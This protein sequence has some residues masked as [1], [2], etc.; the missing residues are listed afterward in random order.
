M[1]QKNIVKHRKDYQPSPYLINTVNLRFELEKDAA[2]V[3]AQLDMA[4]AEGAEP[5][6]L[7]LN[8]E[9]LELISV[10]IDGKSL[11][12]DEYSVSDETLTIDS[13]P[14]KF[15][16]ETQV[17]IYPDKNK[18]LMGLYQSSG[19]YC[20]QCESE[21]FR[22]I[23]YY[24]DRSD[25]LATF[26]TTIIADKKAYPVLLANGNKVDSAH[27]G[28]GRHS[29]TWHDPFKKPSYLF[30]MVAG[31]LG[32]L[33][34]H[35]VTESNRKVELKI[36][37]AH[38]KIKHC[39]FAMESL[40]KAMRW[41][42][43]VYGREYDLDIFMIVAVND[44]NFGAMENKGLNIFNDRYILASP[45]TATDV[46]YALIDAVVAHEYF[47]NWSGNRVTV[48]DWFQLSLKEGLT[49]YRDHSFSEDIGLKEV[50]RIQQVNRL[51]A[52]QF[53]EDAGPLAHPIR[54]DSYIEMGNFYT[55]TVYEKG[56]EVIRMMNILLGDKTYRKGTDLYFKRHDGCAVTC[57]D[58]VKAMED[59]SG[60]DLKQFRL[61]YSQAGTPKL[62]ISGCYDESAKEF[63]L[64]VKQT[65]PATPGQSNKKPMHI[66]LRVALFNKEGQAVLKDQVLN[67]HKETE[68]FSFSDINTPVVPSLLRGFSAPV[69]LNY[70][71][72][73]DELALLMI[74]DDDGFARWEAGQQYAVRV[75]L[76]L[77]KKHQQQAEMEV[78]Q[79]FIQSIEKLLEDEQ[80]NPALIAEMLVLPSE[81][82]LA[83]LVEQV[84]ID[85]IHA[86]RKFLK[87]TIAA[88]L[89]EKLLALYKTQAKTDRYEYDVEQV[90][91]RSLKNVCLNYLSLASS[92]IAIN[93][94]S[95][96]FEMGNNMTDQLAALACLVGLPGEE[97]NKALASFY[98]QWKDEALVI[99]K[100]FAVQA[101]ADVPD[102][103][104]SVKSLTQH[105]AFKLE[106]PNKVR[107]L[108]GTF[109]RANSVHFHTE[110]GYKFLAEYIKKLDKINPMVASRLLEP[111]TRW[112]KLDKTRQKLICG[113]LRDILSDKQLSKDVYEIASKTLEAV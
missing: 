25:V 28:D 11:S 14:E 99:D 95:K 75:L 45:D 113:H 91:M 36:F 108:I 89:Q 60:I 86:A 49:V 42:E 22:R 32:V 67:V 17:R 58:F 31:D 79:Q 106:N 76:N 33:E 73:E 23:T 55:P 9:M 81:D 85:A 37:A 109:S 24:I 8:G 98:E 27:E 39:R 82:Y 65:I 46:D 84:D 3:T 62:D 71:Y 66:P 57:E 83:G 92:N 74:C 53:P 26:T 1:T 107:A 112:K 70:D 104:E 61:W 34:D 50:V 38:D 54:P 68:S 41:D 43:K 97:A 15:I 80:I 10:Q 90:A 30:A 94:T 5:Q 63:V 44:F 56:A 21:G 40:K 13:V 19:V 64:T 105:P 78:A 52:I 18:A 12:K 96:Q 59:A 87:Q 29:V 16:L 110:A 4:R 47:H 101:Q 102:A 35:F 72:T 2:I 77:V 100:W 48:R 20:T 51:R 7:C 88:R 6:A 111:F 103:L 93:L 69:Y